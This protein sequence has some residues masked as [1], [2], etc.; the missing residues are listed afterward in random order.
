[1]RPFRKFI[2][3]VV[4]RWFDVM[5]DTGWEP[6][7]AVHKTVEYEE[8]EVKFASGRSLVCADNHILITD[9]RSEIFAKDCVPGQRIISVDGCDTVVSVEDTNR[10]SNMY[11]LELDENSGHVYFTNGIL[12]HNT[13]TYTI[14]CL[15][16]TT[17]YPEKRV[18]ICANALNT[19]IEIMDRIRTAYEQL[20]YFLKASVVTYNKAEIAF[21]NKSSIKAFATSSSAARGHSGNVIIV[22]EIAFIPKGIIDEFFSSVMPIISS[23][24]KSKAIL[25]STPNGTSGLYYDIWQAA[26]SKDAKA[27]EDGWKPIRIDW[28]EVPG[29]DEKWKAQQ[30]ATM[31]MERWRQEFGNEFIA[32]T[33]IYKL[34]PDNQIEKYRMRI[35]EWRLSNANQPK[36]VEII[37]EKQDR[38]FK[39]KMWRAFDPSRTYLATGDVSEG[40][41]A[42]FSVIDVWDIT[43]TSNIELCAEYADNRT[44]TI[45]F[46]YI[47]TKIMGLYANPYFACES[48]GLGSSFLDTLRVSYE[49]PNIVQEGKDGGYGIRSHVQ[50]KVRACVWLNE[51][52]TTPEIGWGLYD[53]DLIDEMGTFVRVE[54]KVH[55][56]YQAMKGA[57]DDRIMSLCWCAYMLQPKVVER[58]Y[59]VTESIT[60]AMDATLP[61]HIVPQEAYDKHVVA[62][63]QANPIYRRFVE[64]DAQERNSKVISVTSDESKVKEGEPVAPEK[65]EQREQPY[66]DE[67][68]AA[69][70]AAM[71]RR[72]DFDYTPPVQETPARPKSNSTPFF[73]SNFGVYGDDDFDGDTWN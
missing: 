40:T 55:V 53:L 47:C 60:T 49:Y 18:M 11:D 34:I 48:N 57:H 26:I 14:F 9:S 50:L 6:I 66:G 68:Q 23:S 58:Y 15:W 69:L 24:K 71:S 17:F 10:H 46:A 25:V 16:L 44:T 20:P 8:Y 12:S 51:M 65:T 29:R 52:F 22:D 27:N 7:R 45:E 31:G 1:M 30:I 67:L 70:M 37:S 61:K 63:I 64:L 28:W 62:G 13:T 54:G 4:S 5:T 38:V 35:T 36:F 59:D 19:A 3:S 56:R 39:F 32:G 72:N 41:G 21:S 42:D 2:A 43:D 73:V 33:S